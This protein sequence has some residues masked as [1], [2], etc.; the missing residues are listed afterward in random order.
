[1]VLGAATVM[2]PWQWHCVQATGGIVP[3]IYT[4]DFGKQKGFYD[5]TRAWTLHE[6]EFME[7]RAS[8]WVDAPGHDGSD[9]PDRAF[10]STADR[11]KILRQAA[12]W[13]Q[14]RAG[15]P[16]RDAFFAPI[17]AAREADST[18]IDRWTRVALRAAFMWLDMPSVWR[19]SQSKIADLWPARLRD[20][21][22]T[23]TATHAARRALEGGASLMLWI[24]HAAITVLLAWAAWKAVRSGSIMPLAILA[25]VAMY[26]VMTGHTGFME[27]RRNLPFIPLLLLLMLWGARPAAAP[28]DTDTRN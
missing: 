22:Q 17:A 9:L 15:E 21:H 26:S 6:S 28:L 23:T 5:W 2:A 1:M 20:I 27:L 24:A 4:T 25:G 19:F 14:S 7:A 11:E 3:T 10:T 16:E 12:A 13:R 8:F 18:A